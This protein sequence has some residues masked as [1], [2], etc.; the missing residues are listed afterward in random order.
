M[1]VRHLFAKAKAEH[2]A[3]AAEWTRQKLQLERRLNTS[4][5]AIKQMQKA[6]AEAEISASAEVS[7]GPV[8]A[9]LL[10]FRSL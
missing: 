1:Q 2:D 8:T 6:A 3:A 4:R 7:M 9:Q 5:H 10:T